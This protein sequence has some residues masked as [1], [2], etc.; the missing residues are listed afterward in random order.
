MTDD[1]IFTLLMSNQ[2]SKFGDLAQ[3]LFSLMVHKS[4]S[5]TDLY[6][7][8]LRVVKQ[9]SEVNSCDLTSRKMRKIIEI[10]KKTCP[11]PSNDDD[12]IVAH[13]ES[14][15]RKDN[16]F[17]FKEFFAYRDMAE[18]NILM[19]LAKY[20][21]DGA[22]RELLTH[23]ETQKHIT[24]SV[25]NLSNRMNQTILT[26]IEVNRERMS[27]SLALI[28]KAEYACHGAK[29]AETE[30]CLSGQIETSIASNEIIKDLHNLEPMDWCQK[31]KIWLI[32]FIT[33]LSVNY[34]LTFF[35]WYSDGFL[36]VH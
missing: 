3:K 18:N 4:K 22:L 30:L 20:T 26:I 27:E 7:W 21:M 23:D 29:M 1:T 8:L 16:S 24:H 10:I 33:S 31:F 2:Y 28:L 36:G 13:S 9:M 5:R 19:I 35:D 15:G 11:V 25:L 34:F 14:L 32:L 6:G 12:S 17:D